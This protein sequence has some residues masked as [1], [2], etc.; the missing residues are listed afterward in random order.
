[1]GDK[2]AFGRKALARCGSAGNGRP[3]WRP[4]RTAGTADTL[5]TT[6]CRPAPPQ[7]EGQ[8]RPRT[9]P[10]PRATGY[11]RPPAPAVASSPDYRPGVAAS[12]SR[13]ASLASAAAVGSPWTAALVI[14]PSAS[15]VR[16]TAVAGGAPAARARPAR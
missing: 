1:M 15:R 11:T 8:R 9:G 3:S 7:A 16:W 6:R 2:R 14:A 4:L 13:A 10:L 5:G 12:S